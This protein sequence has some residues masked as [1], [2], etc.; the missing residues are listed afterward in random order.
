MPYHVTSDFNT[1]MSAA[2]VLLDI[3]RATDITGHLGLLCKVSKL[4]F[5]ISSFLSE[6]KYPYA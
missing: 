1:D 5:L 2:V 4:Q 3:E 6:R